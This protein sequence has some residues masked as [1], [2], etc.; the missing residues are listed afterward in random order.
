MSARDTEFTTPKN[1]LLWHVHGSWTQAL[2][3]GRHRYLIPRSEDS[4]PD[5]REDG[6]G[7]AGRS[8]PNAHE[9]ALPELAQCDIDLVVL[10]RP[11]DAALLDR[12]AGRRAGVD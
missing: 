4:G 11:R 8:W 10:Q 9:V 5:G 1:V 12:W 2:V 6:L 3:A 7:L